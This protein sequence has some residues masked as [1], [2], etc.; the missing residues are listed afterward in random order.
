[1]ELELDALPDRAHVTAAP[2]LSTYPVAKEDLALVVDA[3]VP[4]MRV[5]DALLRGGGP[6]VES[7]RLFDVYRGD[8]V[9]P[10]HASLAFSLRLRADDRTLNAEDVAQVRAAAVAE[11]ERATGAVLRT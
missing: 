9:P 1:M 2:R 4:S 3:S 8:Q 5:A 11:A 6:L 10:G 7:V